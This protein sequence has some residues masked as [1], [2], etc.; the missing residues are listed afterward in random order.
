[1]YPEHYRVYQCW[2]SPS[3][4]THRTLAMVAPLDRQDEIL[5]WIAKRLANPLPVEVANNAY[6]TVEAPYSDD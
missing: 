5:P 6:F 1:M 2:D 3:G 4:V